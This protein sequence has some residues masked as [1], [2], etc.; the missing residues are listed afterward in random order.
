MREA[1]FVSPEYAAANGIPQSPQALSGH[2][3]IQYRFIASRQ[4]APLLLNDKGNNLQVDMPLALIANDTD[5][6]LDAALHGLGIGRIVEPMVREHF[7][8]GAL[9]P[10]LRDYWYPYEGLFVYFHQHAQKAKRVRVLVD[11]LL[12]KA[13]LVE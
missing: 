9:V 4:L 8:S 7:T 11:F 3:L 13:R 6:M 2:K 12:E 10:V 1:L 5:L